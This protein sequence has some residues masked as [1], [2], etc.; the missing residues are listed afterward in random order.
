MLTSTTD[1]AVVGAG[2][3][4]LATAYEL[5][6]AGA[7][8]TVYEAGAPG[9]GQSAGDARI[10]RHAHADARLAGFVARSRAIWREWS[11]TF[12]TELVSP[13]GAVALGPAVESRMQVLRTL[14]DVT[15]RPLDA[16]ELRAR[17]PLLAPY[18]GPAML[19]ETGGAIRTRA[20]VTRL[21]AALGDAL[22]RDHV[23][24]LRRTASGTVEVRTGTRRGTHAY[25]VVCAGLGT[26]PLAHGIG[27]SLPVQVSAHVRVTFAVREAPPR[28]LATL[29]DSS[30]AFGE[31][32]VYAAPVPDNSRYGV[33]LAASVPVNDDGRSIDP[34]ALDALATRAADYVRVAL[35]G[36]DPTPVGHVHCWVT[37]LPWGDD[38]VAVWE[39]DGIAFVAGHNLYKQ[40]PALGVELAALAMT[41]TLADELRPAARLG[42]D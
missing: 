37:T 17:L 12:G 41:G 11:D 15:V 6:R 38:G 30:G 7:S 10:F 20:A 32:G 9:G 28:R 26:A 40:A 3:V 36:L 42:R 31:E 2:I 14:A 25:V 19:D 13:D 5:T 24:T 18:D 34:A 8:V 29:Q 16:A 21:S 22:V 33:G 1:V 39:D 23:L 35:P 4:G 27:L